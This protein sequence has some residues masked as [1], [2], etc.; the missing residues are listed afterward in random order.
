MRAPTGNL[1]G[2]TCKGVVGPWPCDAC[3]KMSQFAEV[4]KDRNIVFCRNESCGFRRIIDKRR[5]RIVE[6]DGTI[7]GFD[8]QGNK[9][10]MGRM[11]PL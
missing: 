11:A 8:N 6:N 5:S 9:W 3:G 2:L 10:P 4:S 7:W 1:L